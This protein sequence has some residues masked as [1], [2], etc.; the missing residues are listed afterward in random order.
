MLTTKRVLIATICGFAFGVV[1]MLFAS[2]NPES[3]LPAVTK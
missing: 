1:C 2:S 3:T